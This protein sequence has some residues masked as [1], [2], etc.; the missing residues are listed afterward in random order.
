MFDASGFIVHSENIAYI[1][2]EEAYPASIKQEQRD[3]LGCFML[4]VLGLIIITLVGWYAIIRSLIEE[5]LLTQNPATTQGIVIKR[6]I[7]EDSE[8]TTYRLFYAF[9]IGDTRYEGKASV[10]ESF[11]NQ[12]PE[13][14]P[15][16]ITYVASDPSI[17]RLSGHSRAGLM[18]MNAFMMLIWTFFFI[19]LTA[20]YYKQ[21]RKQHLIKRHGKLV[22]GQ[23]L[24]ITG[25]TDSDDDYVL[26]IKLTFRTPD[27]SE[28]ITTTRHI[29]ANRLKDV[30][31]PT[32]RIPIYIFYAN[33]D[34]WDVL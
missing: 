21:H 1:K 32:D 28:I 14:S 26:I 4:I 12:H 16:D 20:F 15:V 7:V 3:S 25:E 33:K 29:L 10:N 5:S 13:N 22:R 31:L 11:Y 17:F 24:S 8:S 23:L 27:T 6:E 30:A 34:N 18:L 9:Y 2:G 19:I